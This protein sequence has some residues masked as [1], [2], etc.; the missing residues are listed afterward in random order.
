MIRLISLIF[1]LV[2][3]GCTTPLDVDL[4]FEGKKLVVWCI[5]SPDKIISARVDRTYPP[6]GELLYDAPITN[7]IIELIEND[8]VIETLKYVS[9]GV[10]TSPRQYK[11]IAGHGY[12]IRARASGFPDVESDMEMVPLSPQVT[13]SS[14]IKKENNRITID[15]Q[16]YKGQINQYSI[17]ITGTY[18]GKAVSISV[19]NLSRPDAINDN[20]GFRGTTSNTFFYQDVC[21]DGALLKT[22][23]SAKLFGTVQVLN[24]EGKFENKECDQIQIFIRN[25][26]ASYFNFY[27]TTPP[28]DIDLAFKQPISKLYNLKGGYGLLASYNQRT[29]NYLNR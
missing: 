24:S 25:V 9:D 27:K 16:D 23:Y 19:E 18:T 22:T 14:F 11:P 6:T 26:S 8:K 15:L 5:L 17:Q 7:A 21:F 2:F 1:F 28:E 3:W 29:I 12:K 13:G 10:Y 20:C 4:P